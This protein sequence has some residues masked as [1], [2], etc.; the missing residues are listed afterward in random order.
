MAVDL[1]KLTS[2]KQSNAVNLINVLFREGESRGESK[3]DQRSEPRGE[4]HWI[5]VFMI[6]GH[7]TEN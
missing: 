4:G 1:E 6:R 3:K 5:N 2:W 7:V